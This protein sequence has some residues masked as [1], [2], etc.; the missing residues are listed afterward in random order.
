MEPA[1]NVGKAFFPLDEE[2]ALLAGTLAPRQ[3]EHLV[4][5]ASVMPFAHAKSI[6]K[7]LLGVHVSAETARRLSEQV[8]KHVEQVQSLQAYLPYQEEATTR[9]KALRLVMSADGAMVYDQCADHVPIS[10]L[11]NCGSLKHTSNTTEHRG[12]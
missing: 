10:S 11:P 2:L 8:G 6:L 5:L 12:E 1:P 3:Q 4:H 7:D 9:P